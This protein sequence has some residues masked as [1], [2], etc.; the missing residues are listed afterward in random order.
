[1]SIPSVG[2][3]NIRVTAN[4]DSYNESVYNNVLRNSLAHFKGTDLPADNDDYNLDT[5]TYIYGHSAASS[6]ARLNKASY[7][8]AFNPLFD[9]NVGDKIYVKFEDKEYSYTVYK[10]KITKPEDMTTLQGISG[11]KTLTLMTCA[12][13]GSSLNRLNVIA[14]LD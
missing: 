9:I 11:K 13:P 3:K 6:W 14:I 7:E 1:M 4:V 2:I 8:A 12:P 5:N 10:T